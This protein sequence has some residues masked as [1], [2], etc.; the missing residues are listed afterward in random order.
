MTA[1]PLASFANSQWMARVS[2]GSCATHP[3]ES[4][5]GGDTEAA[6]IA[7]VWSQFV[8]CC[9]ASIDIAK[10]ETDVAQEICDAAHRH[11]RAVRAALTA[12]RAV[13]AGG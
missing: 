10:R 3:L 2:T 6:A 13:E 8:G 1:F 4:T 11:E 5:G 9:A 12:A 7:A